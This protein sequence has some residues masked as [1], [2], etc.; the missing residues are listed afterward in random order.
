MREKLLGKVL[1]ESELKYMGLY[2]IFTSY[3]IAFNKL[4]G[5]PKFLLLLLLKVNA[6]IATALDANKWTFQ[7]NIIP[8]NEF[9]LAVLDIYIKY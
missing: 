5:L 3:Q 9:Y 8:F 4:T 2:W 1:M 6:K 7:A